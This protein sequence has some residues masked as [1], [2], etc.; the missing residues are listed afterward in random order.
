MLLDIY[1]LSSL[2]EYKFVYADSMPVISIIIIIII[3]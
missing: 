3:L 2:V 1:M